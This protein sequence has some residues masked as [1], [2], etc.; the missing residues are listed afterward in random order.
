MN[1][2][3]MDAPQ[4]QRKLIDFGDRLTGYKLKPKSYERRTAIF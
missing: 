4:Q 1:K 3:H 2:G